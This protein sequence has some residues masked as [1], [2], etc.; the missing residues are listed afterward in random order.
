[1]E[2]ILAS[3]IPTLL[4]AA[5]TWHTTRVK[6]DRDQLDEQRREKLEKL[7]LQIEK[8]D[9]ELHGHALEIQAAKAA[10]DGARMAASELK[11]EIKDIRDNMVCKDDL[12]RE[13]EGLRQ[14]LA[15]AL[16]HTPP[17][18]KRR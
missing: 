5:L 3:L 6:R 7:E 16:R 9:D 17:A 15:A 11:A 4:V 8:I 12:S 14:Y 2:G 13:M 1:M 18:T 10:S